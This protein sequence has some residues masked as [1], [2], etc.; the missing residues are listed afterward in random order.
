[1]ITGGFYKSTRGPRAMALASLIGGGVS[2]AVWFGSS[3]FYS[4]ILKKGGRF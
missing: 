1:M 4:K 3:Y 2:T